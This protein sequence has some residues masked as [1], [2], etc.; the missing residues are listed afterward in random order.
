MSFNVRVTHGIGDLQRDASRVPVKAARKMVRV[1][2]KNTTEG[3]KIAQ[4]LARAASGRHGSAYYKR[5]TSEMISPL[6]GEYGPHGDVAGR[7]VGGG[8][9]H[10]PPNT[11][12]PKSADVIGPK[13]ASDAGE[14]FD[15][16]FW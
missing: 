14:I 4:A 3:Q 12:L 2:K 6:E 16:L 8:W 13:F 9:R 1:V 5:I 10:G 11:D 15:G 7:A